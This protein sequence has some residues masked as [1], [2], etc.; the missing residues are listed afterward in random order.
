M[1]NVDIY[2]L[3]FYKFNDF[4]NLK[5]ITNIKIEEAVIKNFFFVFN[6]FGHAQS[7]NDISLIRTSNTF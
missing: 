3:P 2:P 6:N 1:Y 4:Y 7:T 5:K